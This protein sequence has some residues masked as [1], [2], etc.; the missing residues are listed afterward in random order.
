ME[1]VRGNAGTSLN[2]RKYIL[3][4]LAITELLGCKSVATPFP[5][6][7]TLRKKSSDY[8]DDPDFLRSTKGLLVNY[9]I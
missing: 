9:Y 5:A 7:L 4:I 2:Q 6:G 1:I 3:D 8:F